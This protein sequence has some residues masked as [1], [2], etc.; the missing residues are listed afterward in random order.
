MRI[1]VNGVYDIVNSKAASVI[2]GRP[3]VEEGKN[4]IWRTLKPRGGIQPLMQAVTEDDFQHVIRAISSGG[5]IDGARAF[6]RNAVE[7]PELENKLI[8]LLEY[9][10][11]AAS[12]ARTEIQLTESV[13]RGK[14]HLDS[15]ESH[16]GFN[17]LWIGEHR[18]RVIGEDGKLLGVGAGRNAQEALANSRNVA[19]ETGGVAEPASFR[20]AGASEDTQLLEQIA[21]NRDNLGIQGPATREAIFRGGSTGEISKAELLKAFDTKV[22]GEYKLLGDL[23]VREHLGPDIANVRRIYGDKVADDLDYR[24][25]ALQGHKGIIDKAINAVADK[26]LKPWLGPNSGDK[27][28]SLYNK[29]EFA[30]LVFMSP[31]Y[32]AQQMLAPIQTVLPGVAHLINGNARAWQRFMDFVPNFDMAGKPSGFQGFINTMR[33]MSASVRAVA[34]PTAEEARDIARAV[35]EG[36]LSP[37]FI[38]EFQ[39]QGSKFGQAVG[40]GFATGNTLAER[41]TNATVNTL[42]MFSTIPAARVEELSR[43]YALIA[44]RNVAIARGITDQ[45]QIYQVAKRFMDRTMYQY[46]AADRPKIF[47]GPAGSMFGLFKNWV[48]QN[49]NDLSLYSSAEAFRTGNLQPL[50]F[51]L[52]GQGILAGVGGTTVTGVAEGLSRYFTDKGLMGHIYEA[53]GNGP[54]GN[55]TAD[56]IYFGLPGFLGVSLQNQLAS[57]GADP[58]QDLN[59]L[60]NFVAFR[61]A[62]KVSTLVNY[63]Q[64]EWRA[65]GSPLASNR[66]ADMIR[67]A[68]G[69]RTLY[70]L[71]SEVS[72]GALRSIR[73]GRPLTAIPD[74][75]DQWLNALGLQPTRIAR[76]YEAA[77]TLFANRN[78]HRAATSR[79]GEAYARAVEQGDQHAM[80]FILRRAVETGADV[81]SIMRSAAVRIRNAARPV[82]RNDF[83]LDPETAPLLDALGL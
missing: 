45:E 57:I 68:I 74:W 19:R 78:E 17:H 10:S 1:L 35:S 38:D 13:L 81:A 54:D 31:G 70:K 16:Y 79:L 25:R 69:P 34:R 42:K 37:R 7:N 63:F 59:F 5:T 48:F 29:L 23:I 12:D 4:L 27:L 52:G 67:Y 36:R 33:I 83:R 80:T 39:G 47:N 32:L 65:T 73:D 77:T 46:S 64:N 72:D 44:G 20:S 6:I 11:K 26:W 24:I 41:A 14:P 3:T 9:T 66:T 8:S 49:V 22:R 60:H 75:Q 51:A 28:V 82:L 61:R 18:V 55:N 62:Q 43:A 30:N 50:M 71:M 56:A 15:N 40:E 58:Q 2:V 76:A 21:R 53:F